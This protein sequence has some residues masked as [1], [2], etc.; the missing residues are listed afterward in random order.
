MSERG[1]GSTERNEEGHAGP[2]GLGSTWGFTPGRWEL[3][4]AVGRE[5]CVAYIGESTLIIGGIWGRPSR[6]PGSSATLWI[7]ASFRG[8]RIGCVSFCDSG[9]WDGRFFLGVVCEFH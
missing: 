8:L 1:E 4:R 7:L 3:W 2:W 5:G 6:R 9:I